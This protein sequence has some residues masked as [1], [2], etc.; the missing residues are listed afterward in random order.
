MLDSEVSVVG[1][2]ENWQLLKCAEKLLHSSH[3][4]LCEAVKH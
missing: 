3:Q 4:Q 2:D 1:S